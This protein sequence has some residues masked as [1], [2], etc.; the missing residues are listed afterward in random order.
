MTDELRACLQSARL[1][2]LARPTDDASLDAALRGGVY[3]LQLAHPAEASDEEIIAAGRRFKAIG[4]RHGVPLLLNT[5]ADLVEAA[6]ADGVHLN[7]DD[8]A[9]ARARVLV[10]PDRL[11]GLWAKDRAE[12]DAA[13]ALE[14]DYVSVG[15][16]NLTPTLGE[17]PAT[18]VDL[19]TYAAAES[20]VPVFAIGGIDASNVAQVL[21]A[22]V[23]RIA[24]LR[25]IAEAP[26]PE[27]AA[28]ELKAALSR[29]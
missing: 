18:G 21:S 12:V 23:T 8:G 25:V 2:L 28:A 13:A 11:V 27:R 19:A 7:A 6:G 22:G 17:R 5:R 26:D 20:R 15:P 1:Y 4:A 16:I 14:V 3:L 29:N 24:V 10:G 9:V